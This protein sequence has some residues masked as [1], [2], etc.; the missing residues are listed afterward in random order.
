MSHLIMIMIQQPLNAKDKILY[1]SYQ[2][3]SKNI[4]ILQF[5]RICF[6][7]MILGRKIIGNIVFIFVSF[8]MSYL[9]SLML[10]I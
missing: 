9:G 5:T 7:L 6:K 3:V 2:N 1:N 10:K 8:E 4:L